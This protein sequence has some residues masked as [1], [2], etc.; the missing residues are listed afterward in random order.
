[1]ESIALRNDVMK[2]PIVFGTMQGKEE[3]D[4]SHSERR[5]ETEKCE[6]HLQPFE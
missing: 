2:P 1:M 5:V 3:I 4:G 6:T